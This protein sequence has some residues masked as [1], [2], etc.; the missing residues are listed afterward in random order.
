MNKK[1]IWGVIVIVVLIII[2]IVVK[3]PASEAVKIGAIYTLTGPI[4]SYGEFQKQSAETAVKEINDAGGING[5]PVELLIED[6]ASDAKKGVDAYQALK[7]K[8]VKYYIVEYSPVAAAVRPLAV[9]DGNLVMTSGATT[10][11]YIDGKDLSCR[12]T[13]TAKDIGPA[14]AQ[15]AREAGYTSKAVLLLPNNEYGTGLAQEFEK[16]YSAADGVVIAKEF[17]DA[18]GSADFRTNITKLKPLM[19]EAQVLITVN[20]ANTAQPMFE[21]LQTLGWNK[22][23]L[24]DYNTIQNPAIKDKKLVEGVAFVDWTYTPES[25]ATDSDLTKNF[26]SVYTKEHNANPTVAAAGYYDGVKIIL[27]AIQKSGTDPKKVAAYIKNLKNYEVITGTI[28]SFD[29][30]CQAARSNA[31][32]KVQNGVVV[33][34]K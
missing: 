9:E 12:L 18:S 22:P 11:A 14:L 28:V 16:A 25:K 23:I 15:Y 2:A 1:I 20:V 8:G 34:V 13:M 3:K 5:K 7:L 21:Q 24:S 17:Y 10:P 29:E 30:D 27:D 6:S 33:D 4:A 32:R 19:S 31:I 26:K